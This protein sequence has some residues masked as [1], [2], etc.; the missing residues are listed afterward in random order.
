MEVQDKVMFVNWLEMQEIQWIYVDNFQREGSIS[1]EKTKVFMAYSD[2]TS[3]RKNNPGGIFLTMS[4]ETA[5]QI[6]S[7]SSFFS[8]FYRTIIS[9][10]LMT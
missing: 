7:H 4:S 5:L 2:Q 6:L 1:W 8:K 9:F 3:W 10:Y